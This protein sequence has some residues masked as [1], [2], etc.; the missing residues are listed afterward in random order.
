MTIPNWQLGKNPDCNV[1][2]DCVLW[3]SERIC[4]NEVAFVFWSGFGQDVDTHFPVYT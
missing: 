4:W 3:V 1:L 2:K